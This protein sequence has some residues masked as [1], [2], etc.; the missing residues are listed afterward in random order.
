MDAESKD[1]FDHLHSAVQYHV[2]NSLGWRSL[3]P[4]QTRAVEPILAGHH[5]VLAAPTAGG[6]TEAAMLPLF[7]RMLTESWQ[8]LSILYLCP[9]KALLND[10]E[11]RLA[12]YASMFG[13]RAALWHGDVGAG[14]RSRIRSHPPDLLLTT[15]ESLEVLLGTSATE[16]SRFF[17]SLRAVVVDELHAFAADDRGWHLLTVLERA[18]RFAGRQVQ[19]IGLTATV[20]NPT[21]LVGWLAGSDPG[22]QTV[23]ALSEQDS[24]PPEVRI[25][26]VGS[27]VNAAT[28]ISRLHRGEKRLVFCDSRSQ[29]EELAYGLRERGVTT[30]VSHSSIALEDRKAAGRAFAEGQNC[31]IVATSTLELGIDVGDLDRVIQIDAPARVASFLQRLGRS[32]RR[33]GTR[34]N[35]LF[36]ATD[37]DAV[38][39]AAGLVRCW[40]DGWVEPLLPPP[41]PFHVFAQQLLGLIRQQGGLADGDWERWLGGLPIVKAYQE[42]IGQVLEYLEQEEI[43]FRDSGIL[44][45]GPAGEHRF[46]GRRVLELYS[47]FRS[48]PLVEV[49]H[50]NTVIGTVDASSFLQRK[51]GETSLLLNGR[52]W[53][54]RHLDWSHW[55]AWVEPLDLDKGRSRWFGEGLPLS[56]HLC[57]TLRSLL[58]GED[59]L[60]EAHLTR[61]GRA[62]ME[63]LRN[64]F[65][66]LS[67]DRNLLLPS[68]GGGSVLWTFGGLRANAELARRLLGAG[69]DVTRQGNFA[70]SLRDTPLART[71]EHALQG[72]TPPPDP[73]DPILGRAREGLALSELVPP[74]LALETVVQR[75]SDP[76]GVAAVASQPVVKVH[77]TVG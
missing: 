77:P 45:L 5:L 42:E 64:E 30:W 10:L 70:L 37:R 65:A 53:R 47:V 22:E 41:A 35:L 75:W 6:K 16:P 59:D 27:L 68:P 56:F 13:R 52:S 8:P 61:R 48:R 51:E 3:R 33:A 58:C 11:P 15:P 20:G 24:E 44:G 43:T 14:E 46:R 76:E 29:V 39:T 23:V 2:V 32:G 34:R 73:E 72:S 55:V 17:G 62:A 1:P 40:R 36:L 12:R 63:S 54:V 4:L 71:L 7:S 49:R 26:H 25:D 50:G 60:V 21:E 74:S 69:I 66:W 57:R 67:T 18:R 19:R 28:V 31:V 38:L 9:L